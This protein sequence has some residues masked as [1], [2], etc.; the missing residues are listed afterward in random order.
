[1]PAPFAPGADR[2]AVQR[3]KAM[4]EVALAMGQTLEPEEKP[5]PVVF[6]NL[7]TQRALERAFSKKTEPA[8]MRDLVAQYTQK[9]GQEPKRAGMIFRT[10]G[11]PDF[12]KAM[13]E[14]LAQSEDV[15]DDALRDLATRR[16]QAVVQSL[17]SA[18]IEP[19]RLQ[20]G[21]AKA[22]GGDEHKNVSAELS[23]QPVE[24]PSAASADPAVAAR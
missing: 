9:A 8:A 7:A 4:R 3:D 17:R 10:P 19:A 24:R 20:P 11:D 22:N 21:P 13:F 2:E 15:G 18:G 5:G 23:L 14:Q 6:E 1:V 12:Y 16:A